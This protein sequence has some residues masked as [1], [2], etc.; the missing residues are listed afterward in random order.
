MA[1]TAFS[2]DAAVKSITE[3]GFVDLEDPSVGELVLEME[4]MR[5]ALLS[6]YGLDYCKKNILGETVEF[7]EMLSSV[8]S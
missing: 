8:T 1:S 4:Q 3:E 2:L 5:F 7:N 6:P